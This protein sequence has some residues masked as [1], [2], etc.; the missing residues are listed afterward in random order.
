MNAHMVGRKFLW[1]I[2]ILPLL[3]ALGLG[4]DAIYLMT[5]P[6]VVVEWSTASELDTVGFNLYRSE[7]PEGDFQAVNYALIPSASDALAGGNYSYRDISV[8]AG[9][10]YYYLLEDVGA[11]GATNRNGPIQV[12]A[13]AGG[14]PEMILTGLLLL[15]ASFSLSLLIRSYR[16][17]KTDVLSVG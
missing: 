16:G 6:A 5:H 2:F 7:N 3:A 14:I 15:V 9:H 4:A 13:E 12:K 11:D 1:L 10:T 8:Q 17:I